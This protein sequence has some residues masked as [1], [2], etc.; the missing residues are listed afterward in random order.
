LAKI[1]SDQSEFSIR[2]TKNYTMRNK[3]RK[4]RKIRSEMSYKLEAKTAE[5]LERKELK[6]WSEK[7]GKT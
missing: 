2:K 6:T 3:E 1:A 7:S 5:N 4:W